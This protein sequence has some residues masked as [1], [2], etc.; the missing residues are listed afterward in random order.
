MM[1]VTRI[2]FSNDIAQMIIDR[3]HGQKNAIRDLFA[4][5]TL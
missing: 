4:C 5:Q 2:Q 3:G 1:S